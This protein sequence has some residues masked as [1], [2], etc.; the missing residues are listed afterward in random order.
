MS[1]NPENRPT[2]AHYISKYLPLTENWIYRTIINH[3]KFRPIFLS[4]KKENLH[5]F[6]INDLHVLFDR[7][8]VL[9]YFEIFYFVI[10]RYF[11]LFEQVC[12]KHHVKILHIH[13]GYHGAKSI[14]LKKRLNV[15]MVCSFYGDDAF[16]F[17][18]QHK[19]RNLFEHADKILVLGTYM[20]QR[21]VALGCSPEKLVVHHLGIDVDK[22]KYRNR[23]VMPDEPVRFLIAASFLPKKGIDLAIKALASLAP[24]NKFTL[25][26]VGDG[27]LKETLLSEIKTG[28]IQDRVKLH[29]YRPYD[30]FIDLTY[31]CHVFIQASR[32]TAENAKEGTPM[33][34]VDAMAS[35]LAV[36]STRHSDIPEIVIDNE[37]G[38]LAEENN[39]SELIACLKKIFD[40]R[41]R[42]SVFS[43]RGRAHVELEFD[44][45]KQ[46]EKL[47]AYY[48]QLIKGI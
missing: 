28:N 8:I 34:I 40:G 13:F 10:F 48:E 4:R 18:H 3:R 7:S 43:E 45:R 29:G 6:P 27:P 47:E 36:V 39:L 22:I 2:V 33:A 15:P 19:Y 41:E 46:T 23:R 26:I 35:G 17:K 5:L 38:Y 1:R 9:R 20:Q 12:R 32:T 16:A 14:G 42:I 24:Q 37:T 11:I 25:D 31:E 21:L 44:A 30:Y